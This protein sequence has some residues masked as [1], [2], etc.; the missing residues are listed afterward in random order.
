VSG[1][2][3]PELFL[4]IELFTSLLN[5]IE[6]D[7]AFRKSYRASCRNRIVELGLDEA[8][9]WADLER[10]SSEYIALFERYRAVTASLPSAG[11]Q[12]RQALAQEAEDLQ[13]RLCETRFGALLKARRH[14]GVDAFHRILYSVVAPNLTITEVTPSAATAEHLRFLSRGCR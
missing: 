3:H 5:G 11:P 13:P 12:T 6:G 4:P 2:R 10:V 14:F 8:Q 9:F 7:E 1:E